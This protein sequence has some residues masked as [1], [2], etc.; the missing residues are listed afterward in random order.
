MRLGNHK[1]RSFK[2]RRIPKLHFRWISPFSLL[3]KL[4]DAYV[5]LLVAAS[6][7]MSYTDALAMSN[8]AGLS[9]TMR[10]SFGEIAPKEYET[11][12][13]VE[14]YKSVAQNQLIVSG[15]I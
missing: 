13:L 4:R 6:A 15:N 1:R 5:N 8:F 12:I 10:P 3:A 14:L 11:R 2:L 7:K 9:G